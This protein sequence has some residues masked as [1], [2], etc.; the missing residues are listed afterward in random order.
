MPTAKAETKTATLHWTT[1]KQK[2]VLAL[3]PEE[4]QPDWELNELA[5]SFTKRQ[6]D[7]PCKIQVI[8][9]EGKFYMK[10]VPADLATAA[11]LK[12]DSHSG[13]TYTWPVDRSEDSMAAAW[14]IA[15]LAAAWD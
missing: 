14:D 6:K 13:S 2:A 5:K 10:P 3:L 9:N 11:G 8:M 15:K 7:K 4:A 12:L 1:E